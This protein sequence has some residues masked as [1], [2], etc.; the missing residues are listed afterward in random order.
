MLILPPSLKKCRLIDS[1]IHRDIEEPDHHFFPALFA[2]SNLRGRSGLRGL[3]AEL[4]KI[5]GAS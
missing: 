5:A 3:L 1:S 2:E 4:S